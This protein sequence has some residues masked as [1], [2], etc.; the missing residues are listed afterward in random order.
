MFVACGLPKFYTSITANFLDIYEHIENAVFYVLIC[1]QLILHLFTL[2][3][4]S[5]YDAF[6]PEYQSSFLSRQFFWWFNKIVGT[7]KSRPL[8]TSDL[9]DLDP[10]LESKF[11]AEEWRRVWSPVVAEY[12]KKKH[13]ANLNSAYKELYSVNLDPSDIFPQ[14]HPGTKLLKQETHHECVQRKEKN[15]P[16]HPSIIRPLFSIFKWQFIGATVAKALSDILQN[17]NP[18]LLGA[19][20]TFIEKENESVWK[21]ILLAISMFITAEVRSLLLNVYFSAMYRVGVKVQSILTIAVYEQV[22][23]LGK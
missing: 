21:G 20:I 17:V 7:N 22:E 6:F 14:V 4:K 9:F 3:H 1:L 16:A 5:E 15:E 13:H 2:T 11:L 8:V 10:E 12:R 19:L 23:S 18:L